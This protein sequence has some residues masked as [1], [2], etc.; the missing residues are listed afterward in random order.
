VP[1]ETKRP[2]K[3][4][5]ADKL[6]IIFCLSLVLKINIQI[7]AA[8]KQGKKPGIPMVAGI[9]FARDFFELASHPKCYWLKLSDYE[10][11]DN[12]VEI[13]KATDYVPE[14]GFANDSRWK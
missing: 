1:N 9:P 11:N 4:F 10:L 5:F 8:A 13:N 12:F 2:L 3:F 6:K 7:I 14:S